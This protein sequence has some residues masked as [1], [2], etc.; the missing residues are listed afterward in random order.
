MAFLTDLADVLR[1]AGLEV[2]EVTGW[3]TRGAPASDGSRV[4]RSVEAIITHHTAT[5]T[6]TRGD[7]P[8]LNTVKVGRSDLP[9]PLAQLGLGRSGRWYVIAAGRANHTGVTHE[10]W[11]SNSYAI[12]IEA[13]AAGTGDPRD[14][15]EVQMNS[16]AKGVAALAKHYGVPVD[17]V[18]GH[19]EIAAPQGRKTDPSFDMGAFRTRVRSVNPTKKPGGF[20]MALNDNEQGEVYRIIT[21]KIDDI[22]TEGLDLA[23]ALER[24][25]AI[26]RR[27]D[28]SRVASAQRENRLIAA[29]EATTAHLGAGQAEILTAVN[30]A[31]AAVAELDE[32]LPEGAE[33]PT[34]T[35]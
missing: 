17:R 21:E 29:L 26:T 31:L 16:Y 24:L 9:G 18:L 32:D 27:L 25:L 33:P 10:P 4:L 14:W 35:A 22:N 15:P 3:K 7:Y 8:T 5:P 30:A 20:L 2:T 12:G 1:M 13:E 23:S 28:R 19:K 34:P 11:Q 6:L